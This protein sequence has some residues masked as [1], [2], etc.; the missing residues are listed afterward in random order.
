MASLTQFSKSATVT[1]LNGQAG[2]VRPAT[3]LALFVR[4]TGESNDGDQGAPGPEGVV[5][6]LG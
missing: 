5:V 2:L 3:S 4:W 6:Q 1:L